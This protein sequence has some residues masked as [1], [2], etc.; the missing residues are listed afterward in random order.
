MN[1]FIIFTFNENRGFIESG[2]ARLSHVS[3]SM[4]RVA[5]SVL[6]DSHVKT[7]NHVVGARLWIW[8]QFVDN[9]TV[10]WCYMFYFC[11]SLYN[12]SSSSYFSLPALGIISSQHHDGPIQHPQPAGTSTVQVHR[13]WTRRHQ[14]VGMVSEPA[15]GLVLLVHGTLRPAQLLLC[16]REREQSPSS[17]QPDGEDAAAVWT[18][19]RQA[20]WFLD[21]VFLSMDESLMPLWSV[22][23]SDP[24]NKQTL[25]LSMQW[26]SYKHW[27]PWCVWRDVINVCVTVAVVAP[28]FH[29]L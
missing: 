13:H 22:W 19:S 11:Y 29:A 12:V 18:T 21:F 2:T 10:S 7:T 15:P 16:R 14:Q 20:R 3:V 5:K 9:F 4:L 28:V 17:V 1:E 24:T 27:Q 23:T 26:C 8:E 6:L 25:F